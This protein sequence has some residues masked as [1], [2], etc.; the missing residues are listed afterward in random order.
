MAEIY[1]CLLRRVS[2]IFIFMYTTSLWRKYG[3]FAPEP[4]NNVADMYTEGNWFKSQ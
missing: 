1:V 3:L 4:N 2:D